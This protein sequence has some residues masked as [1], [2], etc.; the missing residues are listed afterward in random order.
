MLFFFPLVYYH[1]CDIK[2]QQIF[3]S[4]LKIYNTMY[5]KQIS[6]YSTS[7]WQE[8]KNPRRALLST[9]LQP[10]RIFKT[11]PI[12]PK[13]PIFVK[14]LTNLQLILYRRNWLRIYLPKCITCITRFIRSTLKSTIS[15]LP[16]KRKPKSKW[17]STSRNNIS[18]SNKWLIIKEKLSNHHKCF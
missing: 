14:A 15:S 8:S 12:L 17:I 7:Y 13:W 1:F 18:C 2:Y 6:N 10:P 9:K 3:N 11:A 5:R 16:L 4:Y